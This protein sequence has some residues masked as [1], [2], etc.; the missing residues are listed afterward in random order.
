MLLYTTPDFRQLWAQ[1]FS[2]SIYS[3]F[4][5]A[6]AILIPYGF[7]FVVGQ[8]LPAMTKLVSCLLIL[9][10]VLATISIIVLQ[11]GRSHLRERSFNRTQALLSNYSSD[12]V[13]VSS[14]VLLDFFQQRLQCC[15]VIQATDW[16]YK[17]AGGKSVP[18]SCCRAQVPSCG[19]N[20]LVNQNKIYVRGCAEPVFG[21][22]NNWS[23]SLSVVNAFVMIVTL[24]SALTGFLFE[25]SIR[26]EYQAM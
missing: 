13:K 4:I 18:D 21:Y 14:N 8:R 3:A 26:Q 19:N 5:G 24:A 25:R 22:L 16:K 23:I 1:L 6:L 10:A 2:L 15:G 20:S 17:I 12:D 7:M 9:V 11:T